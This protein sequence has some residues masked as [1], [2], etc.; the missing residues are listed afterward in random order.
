MQISFIDLDNV[1][2]VDS[3]AYDNYTASDRPSTWNSI[4]R[5][6][7][8]ACDGVCFAYVPKDLCSHHLSDM[9]LFAVCQVNIFSVLVFRSV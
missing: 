4:H 8:I 9:N 7:K 1:L 5:Q 3:T 6:E 2:I